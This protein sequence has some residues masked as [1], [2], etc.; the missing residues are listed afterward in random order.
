[1]LELDGS[2]ASER[3]VRVVLAAHLAKRKVKLWVDGCYCIFLV[4]T[5]IGCCRL[6]KLQTDEGLY[7]RPALLEY[8]L[9]SLYRRVD[10]ASVVYA[11]M[12]ART[13]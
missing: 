13:S 8:A 10:D 5:S 11:N 12:A 2:A 9:C 4:V 6:L 3:F 7:P 1:M